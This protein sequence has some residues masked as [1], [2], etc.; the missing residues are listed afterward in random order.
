MKVDLKNQIPTYSAPH[1]A[2]EVV[3]VPPLQ[4]LMIDGNGDPNVSAAYRDALA[5]LYPVAYKLKFLS[6]NDLDRDYTVMP[7]EALWWAADMA[8]FTAT[9]DKSQWSWTA[10]IVTPDWLTLDHFQ[11]AVRMVGRKRGAPALDRIRLEPLNEGLA[12]QTLHIGAYDDEGPTLLRMHE[13][14]IP[15]RSLRMTGKHHEIYL[16]DARRTAPDKLRTV[17]RQ[18]VDDKGQLNAAAVR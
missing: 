8:S 4:Y 14:F 9:R 17:L 16:S 7:L 5:T 11:A 6:R 12:V 10:M 13:Q 1:D 2:F 18:P 3:V 15:S